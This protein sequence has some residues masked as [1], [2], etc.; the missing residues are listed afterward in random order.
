MKTITPPS[1]QPLTYAERRWLDA[2]RRMDDEC[3]RD[4]L[5]CMEGM[6]S[7]FPRRITPALRLVTG[8]HRDRQDKS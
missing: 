6:A 4:N 3:Q 5:V 7:E 8:E 2:F 1:E